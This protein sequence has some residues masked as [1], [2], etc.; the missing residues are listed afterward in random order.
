LIY[1]NNT[2]SKGNSYGTHENYLMGPPGARRAHRAAHDAVF[3][4]ARSSPAPARSAPENNADACD[5]QISQRA[6]F[7]EDRGGPSRPMHSRPIINTR[8]EPNT[9]DPESTAGST[10]SSATPT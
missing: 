6:D 7:L 5:Y 2:T 8:D 10:S 4:T 9:A 3:V 1:K